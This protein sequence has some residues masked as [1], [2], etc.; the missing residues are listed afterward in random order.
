[1]GILTL[2]LHKVTESSVLVFLAPLLCFEARA[3]TMKGS[4]QNKWQTLT[5]LLIILT[6]IVTVCLLRPGFPFPNVS[7]VETTGTLGAYWDS[8][9]NLRVSAIDWGNM[10][11][12]QTKNIT[13]YV[14]N[15]GSTTI[16]LSAIDKN[17]NPTAAQNY[18][19]FV[20]GSDNEKARA[21]EVKKIN[22][23][24]TVSTETTNITNYSFEVLLQG[25]DYLLSDANRDGR[26]DMRDIAIL[27][28]V[29]GTTPTSP[30]WNPNADLNRDLIVNMRDLA[31]ALQ[32][33]AETSS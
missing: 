13:F 9:C 10:T 33:F 7:A 24:L 26:V 2:L 17:W 5:I 20:F 6:G 15:E 28:G 27:V 19:H 32:D 22:C 8:G 4:L 23:S 21:N 18:I 12:G 16:F 31:I 14:R 25:T 3:R 29:F 30:N 11:L 1:M